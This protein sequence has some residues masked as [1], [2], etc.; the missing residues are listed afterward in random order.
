MSIKSAC[1]LKESENM[2]LDKRLLICEALPQN[3][4]TD[5]LGKMSFWCHCKEFAFSCNSVPKSSSYPYF[6]IYDHM[7][8]R[9]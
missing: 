1:N 7:C 4:T 6:C 8:M 2:S 5:I 9:P 3:G